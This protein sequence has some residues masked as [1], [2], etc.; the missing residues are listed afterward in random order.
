MHLIT[1]ITDGLAGMQTAPPAKL[2]VK[3]VPFPR[4][5]FGIYILLVSVDCS[6]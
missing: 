2:N 6:F 1:G 5:Y 3:T 4:L